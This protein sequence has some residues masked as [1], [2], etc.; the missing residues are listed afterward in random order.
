MQARTWLIAFA[1]V[2]ALVGGLLAVTLPD[3]APSPSPASAPTA[4]ESRYSP[5]VVEVQ[6]SRHFDTIS[7]KDVG[8]ADV[9]N[10]RS[11]ALY[12]LVAESLSHELRQSTEL[13]LSSSVAYDEAIADPANHTACA[14]RHIYVDIWRSPERNTWGYSLWSGCSEEDNFAWREVQ[15]SSASSEDD[16]VLTLAARIRRDLQQAVQTGC[17]TKAC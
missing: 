9:S 16:E 1:I 7:F 8:I 3:T 4:F 11:I 12:E 2:A 15:M 13:R 17:F 5:F 6:G 10:D 14:G